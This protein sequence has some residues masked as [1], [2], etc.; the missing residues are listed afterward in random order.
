MKGAFRTVVTLSKNQT[1]V[2]FPGPWNRTNASTYHVWLRRPVVG[3]LQLCKHSLVH[4]TWYI[5]DTCMPVSLQLCKHSLALCWMEARPIQVPE[6]LARAPGHI[7]PRLIF[8]AFPFIPIVDT[9][10]CLATF[11]RG[12]SFLLP[13]SHSRTCFFWQQSMLRILEKGTIHN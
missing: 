3:A 9:F 6:W 11:H 8:S 7:S 1:N 12:F 10:H 2:D 13:F 4:D 5:H